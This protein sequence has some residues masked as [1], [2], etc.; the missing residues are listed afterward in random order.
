MRNLLIVFIK[1]AQLGKVKTRLAATTGDARAL[2][3]YRWLLRHTL[4]VTKSLDCDKVVYYSDFIA[5]GDEWAASGFVQALQSGGDLGE[6]MLNAFREGFSRNYSAIVII[7]SDCNELLPNLLND[8]FSA[9]NS[10]SSVVIGPAH[11]GGYY[12][13]GMTSLQERLFKNKLWSSASVLKNTIDDINAL[14]LSL[15][16]LETLHD[17]DTEQDLIQSGLQL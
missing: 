12:L 3:V 15:K 8:A 11:D 7:G 9:L 4:S 13:L 17:I 14:G 5:H 16:Q 2:E 6:K 1:N 10:N